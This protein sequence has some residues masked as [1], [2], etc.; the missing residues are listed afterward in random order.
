MLEFCHWE[1]PRPES[2]KMLGCANFFCSLLIS[3]FVITP[4]WKVT[5]MLN[6]SNKSCSACFPVVIWKWKCLVPK[7]V[8]KLSSRY[9]YTM[10][11]KALHKIVI[12]YSLISINWNCY[13]HLFQHLSFHCKRSL[14]I[15]KGRQSVSV[16]IALFI[17]LS[18]SHVQLLKL[19]QIPWGLLR[20]ARKFMKKV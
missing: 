7:K 4:F 17:S 1:A 3:L 15:L 14:K 18:Q 16:F 19:H 8:M 20:K 13:L 9:L 11:N 2:R 5:C 6:S 12:Y 10:A